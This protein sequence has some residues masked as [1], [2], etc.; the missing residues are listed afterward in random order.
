MY[1]ESIPST[2]DARAVLAPAPRGIAAYRERRAALETTGADYPRPLIPYGAAEVRAHLA[3]LGTG[4]AP[5]P[6]L[7]PRT[8]PARI[9]LA[10]IAAA[11]LLALVLA[12]ASAASGGGYVMYVNDRTQEMV[13]VMALEHRTVAE[14]R[15]V[16]ATFDAWEIEDAFDVIVGDENEMSRAQARGAGVDRFKSFFVTDRPAVGMVNVIQDG[17]TVY[18]VIYIA[19]GE[20]D[21]E[22]GFD[23]TDRVIRDGLDARKP[24][25]FTEY[26]REGDEFPAAEAGSL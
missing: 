20:Y 15:T 23:F 7:T 2:T 11:I 24:Y 6:A 10:L 25:G 5:G 13:S 8:G 18:L 19:Y 9:V 4:A 12:P 1:H 3:S 26:A 14:A 16:Y 22:T 21:F 17:R